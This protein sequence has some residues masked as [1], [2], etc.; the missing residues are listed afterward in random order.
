MAVTQVPACWAATSRST[1]STRLPIS[2]ATCPPTGTPPSSSIQ[3]P[4]RRRPVE[5]LAAGAAPGEVVDGRG[6]GIGG[7][8]VEEASWRPILAGIRAAAATP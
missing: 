5:Q 3:W 8:Q 1:S 2:I 6:V 4:S 7:D